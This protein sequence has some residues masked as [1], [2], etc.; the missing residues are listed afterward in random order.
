[1][2]QA[3]YELNGKSVSSAQFYAIACDPRRSVAIEACAGAGKTW[4]LVSRML[5]ALLEDETTQAHEILAI[6]FTKKAAGEMRLRLQEWLAEFAA[7]PLEKLEEELVLRGMSPQSANHKREVLQNLYQTLLGKGRG[8]QIRT[9]HGWFAALLRTAPLSVL[10]DLNLPANYQLLEDDKL[11]VPGVWRRFFATLLAEPAARQDFEDLV[12]EYGRAQALKAL[13]E[14]L[15]KRVEFVLADQNGVLESSVPHFGQLYPAFADFETPAAALETETARQN[16]LAWAREL[17]SEKLKTPQNAAQAIITAYESPAGLVRLMALRK[18][19][20]V[21]TEDRLTQH[22][23]KYPAAQ[24]AEMALK[25]L[26][27][28]QTQHLAWLHQ[29]R[30][31]RLTRLLNT[32]FAALKRERGWIDMNDVERAAQHM[33]SS[34]DISGWVQERL[35]ARVKHL[36]IDEFQ[37]TS[38]LQWQA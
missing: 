16:W 6:T 11:A 1:M 38:P 32:E 10:E 3:A 26:C 18:A 22:L 31:T 7:A 23:L 21:A 29:Q 15:S 33:L 4:M 2:T 35:D 19:F 20:F 9:F 34:V 37:D 36:M 30:M 13:E 28:A 14:A 5:R 17:G 24:R 27:D 8:V 25:T 12:Q